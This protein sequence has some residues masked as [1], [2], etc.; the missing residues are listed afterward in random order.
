MAP[1]MLLSV[2]TKTSSP[3]IFPMMS[4]RVTSCPLRSTK[5]EQDVQGDSL[6]IQST[7]GAAQFIGVAVEFKTV[8]EF[9][10]VRRHIDT[11]Y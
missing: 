6:Q 2:S 10:N 4:S 5:Q 11:T 9:H 3:Q 1:L 8:S 7:T